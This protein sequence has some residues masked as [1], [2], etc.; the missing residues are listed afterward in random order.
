MA[1]IKLNATYGLTGTLPAVSGAN[2]TSLTSGNLTGAL[3]AISGASLTTLNASNVS[4]GT[5]NAARYTAGGITEA[6]QWRVH[7][8]FTNAADPIT[9]NWERN[10]STGFEKIGTGMSESSGIFT[11]PSTGVYFI[12]YGFMVSGT[13]NNRA[14]NMGSKVTTDD[15]TYTWVA[16]AQAS[17]KNVTSITYQC[18]A[19]S[20]F[21]DVTDTS[22]HKCQFNFNKEGD[23][24]NYNGAT[25]ENYNFHTFIRLGDT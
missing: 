25:N 24:V 18:A 9:S 19:G 1:Q 23:N 17:I 15:S 8:G 21:F 13:G 6:D 4:S 3:P 2:L 10:D 16:F 11:F 20:Y 14:C 7:T 22:T 12:H 5:L